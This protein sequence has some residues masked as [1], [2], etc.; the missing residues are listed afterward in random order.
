[1][2]ALLLFWEKPPLIYRIMVAG[3][4]QVHTVAARM[5]VPPKCNCTFGVLIIM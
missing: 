4:G 2:K 5:Y 1:M 3:Q